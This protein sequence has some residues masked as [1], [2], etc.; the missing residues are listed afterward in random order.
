M[1]K[2]CSK[3]SHAAQRF[4]EAFTVATEAKIFLLLDPDFDATIL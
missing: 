1:L 4:F 3:M 2:F